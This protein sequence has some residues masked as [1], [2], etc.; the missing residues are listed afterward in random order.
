MKLGMKHQ[1]IKFIIVYSNDNPDLYYSKVEICT[2]GFY[3]GKC[4]ND[5]LFAKYCSL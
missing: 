1:E 3:I 4:V 2:L 5:G